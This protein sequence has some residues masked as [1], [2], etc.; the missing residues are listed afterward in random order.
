V[1]F[2]SGIVAS[3]AP[4]RER[5][6]TSSPIASLPHASTASRIASA[7][8]PLGQHAGPAQDFT[9]AQAADAR[10]ASS[11]ERSSSASWPSAVWFSAPAPMLCSP[12]CRLIRT[13]TLPRDS[14]FISISRSAGSHARTSSGIRKLRSRKR[15]FTVRSS[16]DTLALPLPA[17]VASSRVAL[18]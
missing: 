8:T 3:C 13:S 7:D 2:D 16:T 6:T 10:N 14:L 18:A 15:E 9:G 5:T 17:A 4:S 12:R 1:T 11:T